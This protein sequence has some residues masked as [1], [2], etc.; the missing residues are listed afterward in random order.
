MTRRAV[1]CGINV[2]E[3]NVTKKFVR[4]VVIALSALALLAGC[5]S[6]YR[7]SDPGSGRQYY[8]TKIEKS[9]DGNVSF[10]DAKSG[11]EVTLQ[12]SEVKEISKSD[13][14]AGVKQQ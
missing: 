9:R 14:D 3:R 11:S 12:S 4:G 7:V 8:T 5:A 10:K 6:Y 13:Y 1:P 2:K